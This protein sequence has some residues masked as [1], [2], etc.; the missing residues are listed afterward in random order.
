[1]TTITNVALIDVGP[2]DV[3]LT[4]GIVDVEFGSTITALRPAGSVTASGESSTAQASSCCP[5]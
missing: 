4:G 3:S 2:P 5:V 1:M